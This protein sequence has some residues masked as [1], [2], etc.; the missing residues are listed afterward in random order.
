MSRIA[1]VVIAVPARN[2]AALLGQC[3]R[4]LGAA[5]RDLNRHQPRIS[6]DIVV[7]LDRCTDS[8]AAVVARFRA[9]GVRSRASGVG[10]TRDT[11]IRAG[12]ARALGHAPSTV[13]IA[14]TDADTIVPTHWLSTQIALAEAGTD[15]ILGTVEPTWGV[16]PDLLA[17][18]RE[19]HQLVEGHGHVHGANLGLRLT[20]WL[21]AGGFRRLTRNEDIELVSRL[22]GAG[23][24]AVATDRIRARTSARLTGRVD[25]GFAGYLTN[26]AESITPDA[27]TRLQPAITR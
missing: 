7:A 1:H 11:A 5:A 16:D 4:R 9:L 22:R 14:N 25:A 15:L 19:R 23:V 10:G 12:L 17:R 24:P 3:L 6:V 21:R 20:A 8:S 18:W 2:E 27:S 26:L 13:W